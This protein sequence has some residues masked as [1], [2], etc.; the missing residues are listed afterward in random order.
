MSSIQEFIR[1]LLPIAV[2]SNNIA[3]LEGK[4]EDGKFELQACPWRIS[5]LKKSYNTGGN[6]A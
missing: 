3:N 6:R 1:R 5:H 4:E 2:K